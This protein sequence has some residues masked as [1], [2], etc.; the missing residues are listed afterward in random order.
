MLRNQNY[1]P[2][3]RCGNQFDAYETWP[4]QKNP[5]SIDSVVSWQ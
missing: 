2:C 3:E 4:D 1:E 5:T